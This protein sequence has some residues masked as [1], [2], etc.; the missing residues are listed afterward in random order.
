MADIKK[1]ISFS[2][3]IKK[4]IESKMADSK[5]CHEDWGNDDLLPVRKFIRNYYRNSQHKKLCAYCKNPLSLRAADNC[6]IEHILPKSDYFEFIFHPKNLCVV[7]ADCNLIKSNE[8]IK[9]RTDK[10]L[11]KK[12]IIYP[13]SSS[14]FMIVHPHFDIWDDYLRKVGDIYYGL[15]DL[16]KGKGAFTIYVCGL[17][18]ALDEIGAQ[19]DY[20][21]NNEAITL[22]GKM[23]Q[24]ENFDIE[25]S[26]NTLID[27]MSQSMDEKDKIE[28]YKIISSV[29]AKRLL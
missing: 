29:S 9:N 20:H 7:C 25:E 22:S 5:F 11:K 27:N 15:D 8:D 23:A 17:N 14:R 26:L 16:H 13:R 1:P 6:H 21:S 24:G 10:I 18:R 3:D 2:G 4:V 12:A 28:L 19:K